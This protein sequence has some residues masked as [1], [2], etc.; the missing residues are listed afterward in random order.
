MDGVEV[1]PNHMLS[2]CK[3]HTANTGAQRGSP[4]PGGCVQDSPGKDDTYSQ[5]TGN[6]RQTLLP[7]CSREET[8]QLSL[9]CGK[10][11]APKKGLGSCSVKKSLGGKKSYTS[12]E[13]IPTNFMLLSCQQIP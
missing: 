2:A 8:K 7:Y 1:R 11:F 4:F 13:R 3:W 5:S 12:K 9:K 10:A 6:N